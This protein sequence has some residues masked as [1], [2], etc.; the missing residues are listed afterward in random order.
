[1]TKQ[2]RCARC[3]RWLSPAEVESSPQYEG[4]CVDCVRRAVEGRVNS[5]SHYDVLALRELLRDWVDDLIDARLKE[6]CVLY[7]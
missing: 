3:R 4:Y 2:P 7:R 6:R 1:M 5:V